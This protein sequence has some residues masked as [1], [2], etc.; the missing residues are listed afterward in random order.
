MDST[1]IAS[2]VLSA[3]IT[4]ALL[5]SAAGTLVFSTSNRLVRVIDRVRVLASEALKFE[6]NPHTQTLYQPAHILDQLPLL[7][8]RLMLLRGAMSLLYMAISLLIA[9]SVSIG[10][11]KLLEWPWG[12]NVTL[13]LGMSG[14]V[15]LLFSSILLVREAHL[16]VD[17]SAH[18]MS[19]LETHLEEF[20]HLD[21]VNR[22]K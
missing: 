1:Q 14:S 18:E 10:I 20:A 19:F 13:L 9:T 5:V 6:L 16:A 21:L 22:K 4:P 15:A 7:R 11:V 12:G 3:M 8:Q 2:S 17:S